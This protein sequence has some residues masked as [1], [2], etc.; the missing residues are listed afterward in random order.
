MT[1]ITER[2]NLKL[3][4]GCMLA[5]TVVQIGCS[6]PQDTST[7][8]AFNYDRAALPGAKPWTSED[9]NNSPDNFQFAIIGDRTGGANVL[10]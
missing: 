5:C 4:A 9:F 8:A 6:A 3:F 7:A 1:T 2:S 10:G